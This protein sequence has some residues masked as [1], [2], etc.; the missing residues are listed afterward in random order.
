MRSA[1]VYF[2]TFL[3][4]TSFITGCAHSSK[5]R[6]SLRKA[7]KKGQLYDTQTWNAD[8]IW[9]ATF[10]SDEFR[11]E[12]SQ[13]HATLNHLGPIESARWMAK[14][15]EIQSEQWEFFVTIYT[16][17]LYKKFL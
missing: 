10:F 6:S 12:F 8:A 11:R 2:I 13:E 4:L 5:Y 9:H 17:N 14:Q 7:T 16:K 3:I 1:F 15:G